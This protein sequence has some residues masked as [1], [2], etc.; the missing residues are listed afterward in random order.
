MM[1]IVAIIASLFFAVNAFAVEAPKA[2]D[3]KKEVKAQAV[4]SAQAKVATAVAAPAAPVVADK[5]AK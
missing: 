2:A 3:V 1:K 4:Q 5:K